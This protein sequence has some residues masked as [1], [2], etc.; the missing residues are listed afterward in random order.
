VTAQPQP[1]PARPIKLKGSPDTK[2]NILAAVARFRKEKYP[3]QEIK[4]KLLL[5]EVERDAAAARKKK[6][7]MTCWCADLL[8]Q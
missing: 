8:P 4:C 7:N 6:V 5:E 1:K 3:D 2:Q